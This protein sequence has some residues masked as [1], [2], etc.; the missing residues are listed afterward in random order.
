MKI[1]VIAVHKDLNKIRIHERRMGL[2]NS[3]NIV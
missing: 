3:S 1:H 2:L